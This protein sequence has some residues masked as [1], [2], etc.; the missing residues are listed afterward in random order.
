M[1][2]KNNV[3]LQKQFKNIDALKEHVVIKS[4]NKLYLIQKSYF[5]WVTEKGIYRR[6]LGISTDEDD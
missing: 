5:K 3:S 2:I 4:F 6:M 1:V